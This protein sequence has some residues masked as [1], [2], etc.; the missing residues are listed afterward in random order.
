MLD[1]LYYRFTSLSLILAVFVGSMLVFQLLYY[2]IVYSKILFYFKQK[3][4]QNLN[5]T[6]TEQT[7]QGV[8][9]IIVVSNNGEAL[10][11]SLIQVLEQ[12]YPLFEVVVVNENSSDDTE[13]ILYVLQA[14]YPNLTVINLGKNDNKFERYKFSL[15]I[16][17]RS[18]KYENVLLMNVSCLPKTYNWLTYMMSPVNEN[19][20]KKIIT[21]IS[22][23]EQSKGLPNILEKYDETTTYMNL[24][25]YTLYGNAYTSN[26]MNMI[27]NKQWLLNKQGFISQYAISCNQEDF[28]VHKNANKKNTAIVCNK[29]SFLYLPAYNSFVTFFRVK[30]ATSLSHKMLA[31]KDKLLLSLNPI[32]SFLYYIG[33]VLLLFFGFPWQYITISV[34]IKWIVQII[35]Y[36]KCMAKLD[37]RK[38]WLFAPLCEIF[39]F[40]FNFIIRLK[41]LFYHKREK[42]IKWD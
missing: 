37:M 22:L 15:S 17:I 14:N 1:F 26:G 16:G 25:S 7:Q 27:Y 3:G 36:K 39:F 4:K 35:F 11:D 9:V 19:S 32:T 5:A 21:G 34:V 42:K 12:D 8:S 33:I 2:F 20:N 6:S 29:D 41:V 23:R 40:F 38:N 30:F 10:R 18:A 31:F 24:I 28:F 13:F